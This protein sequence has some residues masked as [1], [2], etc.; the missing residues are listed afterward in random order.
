MPRQLSS[1]AM[2][3][4]FEAQT[5]QAFLILLTIEA[6]G[7]SQ[8]IRVSSDGV[9]TASRGNEYTAFPFQI[10]MPPEEEDK[11][12]QVTLRIDNVDLSI[13]QA[14]RTVTAPPTVT[15]NIV[16][17]SDPDTLEAEPCVLTLRNAMYDMSTIEGTLMHE[18][19][20]NQLT[21]SGTFTP[22]WFSALH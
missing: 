8:P 2:R 22:N 11:P 7:L 13:I 9:N 19:T 12:P 5:D 18:D 4:L 10:G 21:P 6:E 1:T 16:L 14:I 3:A 20:L 17:A 15:M